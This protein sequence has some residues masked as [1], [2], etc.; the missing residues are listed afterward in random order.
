MTDFGGTSFGAERF[1]RS[2]GRIGGAFGRGINYPSPFFDIGHTYLPTT[3]KQMF[4]WCRYY[5][6]VHPLINSVVFKMSQY[7]ITDL[8][9]HT[10]QG[11]LKDSWRIFLEEQL[12]YRAFMEEIG[13]DYHTYGNGL[14]S[15]FYPF[16]KM[17]VCTKCGSA[18]QAKDANYYF[19]NFQ[20]Y[21]QCPKCGHHGPQKV[22]DRYVKSAKG[23]RL[24]RW[25]PEDVDV[26]YNDLTGEYT[27]FYEI[28]VQLKNDI[29]MGK[30]HI[31]E[32]VPQIFIEALKR[33]RAIVFSKDNIYHF[34]RPT[35][36]GKDRGWG[37]PLL[38]PVLKDAFYLQIL[39][40]SQEAIALEHIVPLR[41]LFPQAG[42]ATSDPYSSINLGEW[43][44]S[45]Q[46]EINRWRF[47]N[48][49]IPIL[50][51]PIGNQ[52]I[53]GDG[54][55]LL[56]GQEIRVW[57]E[58]IVTGM[59]VPQELIFGGLSYSGSNVS[60]RMLENVFLGYMTSHLGLLK[61]IVKNVSS[62]MDWE[63]VDVRFKP[64]KMADDLQRKAYNF[65]LNQ[66]G[67]ISDETLVSDAD[68][69]PENEDEQIQKE[70]NRR[71]E[72]QKKVR[73]A[74]ADIEG[75]SQMIMMRWQLK[76][77]QEQMQMQQAQ[78]PAPGEPGAEA[79]GIQ[80]GGMTQPGMEG[81]MPPEPQQEFGAPLPAQQ[82]PPQIMQQPPPMNM[83]QLPPAMTAT[84]SPLNMS[85][86]MQAPEGAE[87]G[88]A[89]NVDLLAAAQQVAGYL[90]QLDEN[91][92]LMALMQMRQQQPEFYQTVLQLMQSMI[93]SGNGAAG[94]PLPEQKPPQRG[95]ESAQI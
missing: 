37:V 5:F 83:P 13:L 53:G 65:Q 80:P 41:V 27:Y 52:T 23:I 58:H 90:L 87:Q 9:Y 71:S 95:P 50:P 73:L 84:Q 75:E 81:R 29:I 64:F 67:K 68:F 70:T 89:M 36:A 69:D 48:N 34:R 32:D 12:R 11:E 63:E 55:A 76:A 43:K 39:K 44:D 60:L 8:T 25:N 19:R 49:Y 10:D 93:G 3:V 86:Q 24:L 85:Q 40:K 79:E 28:P 66:A 35:L 62:Y 45:I 31:V 30:K 88:G 42:S 38:L 94:Q 33:R 16:R 2:K 18:V 22:S 7:P 56:L 57:S 21:R 77:Q 74:Q 61:W 1:V 15:I 6:L 82:M 78:A 17:L 47:D 20:F 72:A 91:S 4:R 59:G 14:V 46:D 51:L 92:R 54:R 26:R